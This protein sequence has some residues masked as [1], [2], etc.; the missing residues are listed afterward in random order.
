MIYKADIAGVA[1][2]PQESRVIAAWLLGKDGTTIYAYGR[3]GAL[4]YQKNLTT[5]LERSFAYLNNEIIG[6]T[7]TQNGISTNYY[8]LTDNLGSVTKITN[9]NA[10]V[11]WESEYTPF[12]NVAGTNGPKRFEGLYTGKDFD[13]DT[14]LTY[15]WN[16][17]RSEDGSTFISEDPA[18]DGSN[19]YGYCGNNPMTRVDPTGLRWAYDGSGMRWF[20][21]DTNKPD[22]SRD[23]QKE[24]GGNNPSGKPD[25]EAEKRAKEAQIKDLQAKGADLANKASYFIPGRANA[26][27]AYEYF[28]QGNY[29]R[30]A[31]HELA[32]IVD[33]ATALMGGA[34][35]GKLLSLGGE[36]FQFLKSVVTKG[37]SKPATT[38]VVDTTAT[39]A[40]S[41]VTQAAA[42]N[43][44]KPALRLEYEAA[45]K[46]LA[47]REAA[48]RAGGASPEAIARELSAARRALGV[49]YKALTPA[50]KLSEIYARNLEKYGDKLGP[51]VDWLRARGKSWEDII[52][53][54]KRPGGQDLKF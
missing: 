25:P 41:A 44:A 18:R 53:S 39:E 35:V 49:E 31:I 51:T 54:A 45:V 34:L 48:L 10:N 28:K 20:D 9:E 7:E 30:A 29:G 17:W 52:E 1:L 50:E 37:V 33:N 21:D 40:G 6:W 23:Y 3:Q 46:G 43:V 4:A 5:G 27:L 22:D 19:W 32:A 47:E 26:G 16:R 38:A 14:G 2:K 8:A 13:P 36:G 12:G 24:N 11:V 42:G 15:H